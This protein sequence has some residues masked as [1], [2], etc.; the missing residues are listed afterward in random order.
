MEFGFNYIMNYPLKNDLN[1]SSAKTYICLP[2]GFGGQT[3]K[4]G[5]SAL[6]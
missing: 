1:Y 6:I 3:I 2:K 5:E 4:A